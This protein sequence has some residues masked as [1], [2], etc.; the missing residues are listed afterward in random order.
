M[1]LNVLCNW[2]GLLS[3]TFVS[4]SICKSPNVRTVYLVCRDPPKENRPDVNPP[5]AS[6]EKPHNLLSLEYLP[7]TALHYLTTP[8]P[9]RWPLAVALPRRAAFHVKLTLK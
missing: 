2:T 5:N 7:H 4:Y 1:L 9:A 8:A 3:S 6:G